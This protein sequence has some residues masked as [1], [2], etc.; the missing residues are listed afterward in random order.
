MQKSQILN[1]TLSPLFHFISSPFPSSPFSTPFVPPPPLCPTP[2]SQMFPAKSRL[3]LLNSSQFSWLVSKNI[4]HNY[5]MKRKVSIPAQFFICIVSLFCA[6]LSVIGFIFQ[7]QTIVFIRR[8]QDQQ[9]LLL[10]W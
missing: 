3:I 4:Q 9:N 1:S 6:C 5:A 7:V 2:L 10:L 8:R